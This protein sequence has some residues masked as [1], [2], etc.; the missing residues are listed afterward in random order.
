M[1]ATAT[2]AAVTP[3]PWRETRFWIYTFVLLSYMATLM[4]QIV[5]TAQMLIA[6]VCERGHYADCDSDT[7][8]S[9]AAVW[10]LYGGLA[11][12]LTGVGVS[13]TVGVLSD[14]F[15]RRWVVVLPLVGLTANTLTLALFKAYSWPLW[16]LVAISGGTGLFGGS[17]TMFMAIYTAV[18]DI[19]P[20]VERSKKFGYTEVS[21]YLGVMAGTSV[22]GILIEHFDYKTLFVAMTV[23]G[24]ALTLIAAAMP[25]TLAPSQ[26]VETVSW[27]KANVFG[28]LGVM[29]RPTRLGPWPVL[30]GLG[31][32][33]LLSYGAI[34]AFGSIVILYS[35]VKLHWTP[36]ELGFFLGSQWIIRAACVSILSPL[37][38][39]TQNV[40]RI[41]LFSVI[42]LC[43]QAG[44]MLTYALA[45]DTGI[46]YVGSAIGGLSAV[47]FPAIRSL[48]SLAVSAKE[49]GVALAALSAAETVA[50][51]LLPAFASG[52]YSATDS[53]CLPCTLYVL[54]GLLLAGAGCAAVALR[55]LSPVLELTLDTP[56]D[57]DN[58]S[59]AQVE[60]RP[61]LAPVAVPEPLAP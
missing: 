3:V 19:V 52:F 55:F 56:D 26:R 30:A 9:K 7:V 36:R 53:S 24:A 35:K 10:T 5:A 4:L 46:M 8:S 13:G 28:A 22:S 49:Q 29:T 21:L 38:L 6:E 27:A 25:E 11:S 61:L 43:M 20:E 17:P 54:V 42:G 44:S 31:L 37:L 16:T 18:A 48:F 45:P 60:S 51:I 32:A 23:A 59:S 34:V 12:S 41:T 47:A 15:G 2:R 1:H 39:H 40:R 14:K 50:N 58:V 33:F 57:M